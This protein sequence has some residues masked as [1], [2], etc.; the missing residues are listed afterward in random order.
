MLDALNIP[1]FLIGFEYLRLVQSSYYNIIPSKNWYDNKKYNYSSYKGRRWASHAGSDS[2]DFFTFIGYID[3]NKSL[4]L[5]FNYERH[6]VSYRFPPEVKLEFKLQAALKYKMI[7]IILQFEN[8]YFEH[9]GFVDTN[10]NV[11][12]ESFEKGSLQ[13]TNTIVFSIDYLLF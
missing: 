10:N 11:W 8:E 5:G 4:I 12:T 9:Y 3:K 7:D 1:N 13:R 2:D 6:G